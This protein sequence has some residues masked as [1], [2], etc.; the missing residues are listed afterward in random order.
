MIEEPISQ[1]ETPEE[2]LAQTEKLEEES[3]PGKLQPVKDWLHKNWK[4]VVAGVVGTAVVVTVVCLTRQGN[5]NADETAILLA[6]QR[7]DDADETV[8]FIEDLS[9]K[10]ANTGIAAARLLDSVKESRRPDPALEIHYTE[11][12]L[13]ETRY[14]ELPVE[15]DQPLRKYTSEFI[16]KQHPRTLTRGWPSEEKLIEAAR[17]GITLGERQTL[18]RETVVN[19]K[20]E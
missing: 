7:N 4:P 16:R 15:M 14:D 17:Q 2:D 1:T 6:R 19:R 13:V 8:V 10:L 11:P 5:K 3:K 20:A 18:V 9:A 12:L